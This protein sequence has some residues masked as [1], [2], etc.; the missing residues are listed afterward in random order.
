MKQPSFCGQ[1]L[2]SI[3]VI[4][5]AGF[6]EPAAKVYRNRL[7]VPLEMADMI[8]MAHKAMI[9]LPVRLLSANGKDNADA[10]AL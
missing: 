10:E 5:V 9:L 2:L 4:E 3:S 6:A 8:K 7:I 1:E